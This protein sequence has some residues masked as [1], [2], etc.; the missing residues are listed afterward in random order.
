VEHVH[1]LESRTGEH[2]SSAGV[3]LTWSGLVKAMETVWPM[4]MVWELVMKRGVKM[5]R[6]DAADQ[7]C[8]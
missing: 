5:N 8:R 3:W 1:G 2:G 7:L 6:A 4:E